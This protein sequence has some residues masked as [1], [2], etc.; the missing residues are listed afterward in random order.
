M[1]IEIAGYKEGKVFKL[2][3]ERLLLMAGAVMI[4]LCL[5]ALS[6]MDA[7]TTRALIAQGDKV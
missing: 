4:I 3:T 2:R 1:R 5:Y 7:D 6:V